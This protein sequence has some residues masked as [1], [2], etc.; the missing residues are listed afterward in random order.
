MRD[1]LECPP[2]AREA[3][4]WASS[5]DC[6][7]APRKRFLETQCSTTS[8]SF[9]SASLEW[10]MLNSRVLSR[11][12]EEKSGNSS[13]HTAS[14]QMG[15]GGKEGQKLRYGTVAWNCYQ[16]FEKQETTNKSSR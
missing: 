5:L 16:T 13:D 8:Q 15:G 2:R 9:W 10:A 4:T 11:G 7:S 1:H 14:L 12:P 6:K 3:Q